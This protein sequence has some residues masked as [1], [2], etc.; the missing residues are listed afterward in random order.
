[1]TSFISENKYISSDEISRFNASKILSLIIPI[2][3][4]VYIF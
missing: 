4:S 3:S 2:E 1:M